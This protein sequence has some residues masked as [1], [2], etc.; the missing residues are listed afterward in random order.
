VIF[1]KEGNGNDLSCAI[2]FR[3]MAAYKQ[4]VKMGLNKNLVSILIKICLVIYDAHP[5]K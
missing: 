2:L 4:H 1:S 5:L 3:T